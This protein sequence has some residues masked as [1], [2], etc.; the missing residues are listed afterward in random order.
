MA[1]DV[2]TALNR[3]WPI[4]AGSAAGRSALEGWGRADPLLKGFDDLHDLVE[5][6]NDTAD[7]DGRDELWL[8]VL[9]LAR[10]DIDARRVALQ[11]LIPG[12]SAV[13]GRYESRWGRA[14]TASMAVSAALQRIATY[15]EGRARR[16]A[17]NMVRDTQHELYLARLREV[18]KE[19]AADR[20][21]E[22]PPELAAVP[23]EPNPAQDVLDLVR[24]A[25]ADGRISRKDGQLIVLTR[26][27]GVLTAD[28][29][30]QEGRQPAAV[31]QQRLRAEAV[32]VTTTEVA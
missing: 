30:R 8:A 14:D 29:A 6:L 5:A 21:R 2:V 1:L 20:I 9:R 18:A 31:R 27:L 12:L 26:V 4:Y 19:A 28:I 16:P 10:D 7:L 13:I 11:A 25:V 32:L 23:A 3:E 24:A 17:A 15:P 22:L